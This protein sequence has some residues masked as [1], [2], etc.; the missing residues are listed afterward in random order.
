M[1]KFS[2]LFE[3]FEFKTLNIGGG[4]PS[5]F[6][7][8]K[9]SSLIKEIFSK[10]KF[11]KYSEKA[12][13][14]NPKTTTFEKLKILEE[15]GFNKISIGVQSLS[16]RVLKI[17]NRSYQTKEMIKNVIDNFNKFDLNYL[18]VDLLLGLKGD[19]VEDFVNSFE[20]VCKIGPSNICIYPVK[21]NNKYIQQNYVDFKN[22]TNFYYPLF[23]EVSKKIISIGKKYGFI[24]RYNPD[25][26]SYIAPLVFSRQTNK[27]IQRIDYQYTHFNLPP[28]SNFCLGYYSHSRIADFIDYLFVDKNNKD[29]MFLKDFSANPDDFIYIIQKLSPR[30]ERVKFIIKKFYL[31]WRIPRKEY[32]EF[33]G[34]DILEDFSY[35]IKALKHFG[36]IKVTPEEIIFKKIDEKDIYPYLLFFAGRRNVLKTI[37]KF[38]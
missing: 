19:T 33:Y 9:F 1:K 23:D 32:K 18:N 27:K 6:S 21:T 22:F 20:E 17:N 26:L 7:E 8:E 15:Y 11:H 30:F 31:N 34:T 38:S 16:Q 4:T 5:I 12:I 2:P 25:N 29:S 35:A 36:I 28:Y 14:L 24:N 13:E 37:K 10:F 3:N